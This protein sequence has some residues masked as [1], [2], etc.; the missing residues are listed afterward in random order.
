MNTIPKC[1]SEFFDFRSTGMATTTELLLSKQI[2][3][4]GDSGYNSTFRTLFLT[5]E[6]ESTFN[7]NLHKKHLSLWIKDA[8]TKFSQT[9]SSTS[10]QNFYLIDQIEAADDISDTRKKQLLQMIMEDL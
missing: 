3:Q 9:D 2:G 5:E 10:T 8:R 1:S 7:S 4:L 6:H